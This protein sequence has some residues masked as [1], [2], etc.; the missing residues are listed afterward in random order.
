MQLLEVEDDFVETDENWL[1]TFIQSTPTDTCSST[2]SRTEIYGDTEICRE[3]EIMPDTLIWRY[4][5]E[6]KIVYLDIYP[7]LKL[8][9]QHLT[10]PFQRHL[11]TS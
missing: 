6:T 2:C 3:T 1:T 10:T 7:S 9:L 4:A 8:W 11:L 5:I